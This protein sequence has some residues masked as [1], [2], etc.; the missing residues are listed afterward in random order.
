MDELHLTGYKIAEKFKNLDVP[1]NALPCLILWEDSIDEAQYITIRK[2][3]YDPDVLHIIQTIAQ[4]IKEKK[5]F[6]FIY[7]EA[8]KMAN[9][10]RDNQKV[11]QKKMTKP[12]NK[13]ARVNLKLL[14]CLPGKLPKKFYP[15][16][17][18]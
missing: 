13:Y 7:R 18:I 15:Y 11:Q 3:Q 2:L 8:V 16:W 6:D 12:K 1:I 4:N 9:E 14:K 17:Q 5:D 10:K